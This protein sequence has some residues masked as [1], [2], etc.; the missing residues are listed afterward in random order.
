MFFDRDPGAGESWFEVRD[1]TQR[2]IVF[3]RGIPYITT[4]ERAVELLTSYATSLGELRA[5]SELPLYNLLP[6][7]PVMPVADTVKRMA[8]YS[9]NRPLI[10]GQPGLSYTVLDPR[11]A[12]WVYR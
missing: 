5:P 3:V 11:D 12:R 2:T 1:K 10:I 7:V 6:M 8:G 9:C 4:P